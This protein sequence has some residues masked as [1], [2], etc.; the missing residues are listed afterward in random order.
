MPFQYYLSRYIQYIQ[1]MIMHENQKVVSKTKN[2]LNYNI[3]SIKV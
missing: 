1:C 2:W 3:Y